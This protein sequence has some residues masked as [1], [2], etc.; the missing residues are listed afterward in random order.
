MTE[1]EHSS[2]CEDVD[3]LLGQA[4]DEYLQELAD[5]KQPAVEAYALNYPSI[6]NLIRRTLP[7]LEMINADAPAAPRI[8]E[9]D[10]SRSQ[11][12]GDFRLLRKLGSGGMGLVYEAEQ[13]SMGRRVAL[14][15]LPMAGTLQRKALERFRNEVRAAAMLDHPNIVSIYSVGEERGVHHFA[16]QLIR[17]QSLAEAIRELAR[18]DRVGSVTGTTMSKVLSTSGEHEQAVDLQGRKES[19]SNPL[20]GVCNRTETEVDV[21]ARVTTLSGSDTKAGYYR[22][23]AQLGVQAAEAL[24][25]AHV[26]GVFHRDIKPGNLMLDAN[27]NLFI[28][29]FGLARIEADVGITR[30][31]DLVGTLRYMSPEQAMAKRAI[32]DARSDI[33]SLGVTLYELVSLRPLFDSNDRQQLLQQITFE[34]PIKL[35]KLNRSIPAELETIIHKAIEKAP[36]DRYHSAAELAEDLLAFLEDRTIQAKPPSMTD[37]LTKWSRRHKPLVWTMALSTCAMVFTAMFALTASNLVIAQERRAAEQQATTANAVIAF[38]TDDLLG[39][40]NPLNEPNRD[41]RL[42]TVVDRAAARIDEK[43]ADQ[44][45]VAAAIRTTLGETYRAL[46]EFALAEEQLSA[47]LTTYTKLYGAE[48]PTTQGLRRKLALA[49]LDQGNDAEAEKLIRVVLDDRLK[50]FGDQHL[51]TAQSMSD[52]GEISL[53]CGLYSNAQR[54]FVHVVDLRLK[55]LGP[56]DPLTLDAQHRLAE[57]LDK[58]NKLQEAEKRFRHVLLH[59]EQILGPEHPGTLKTQHC[60][61]VLLVKQSKLD[62]A[63]TQFRRLLDSASSLLGDDHPFTLGCQANLASTL[64]RKGD[65]DE[66]R[67]LHTRAL[68]ES[69]RNLGTEHRLTLE[70]QMGLA[71]NYAA[72]HKHENA[73]EVYEGAYRILLDEFGET[74]PLTILAIEELSASYDA[75]GLHE[76]AGELR[77]NNNPPNNVNAQLALPLVS[78]RPLSF[79][80]RE[81][82][83]I[84]D[85]KARQEA[86]G[87]KQ[88]PN[89]LNG[90]EATI[91]NGTRVIQGRLGQALAFDGHDD[92]A[93]IPDLPEL[94]FTGSL[95]I[96]CCLKID[97]FPLPKDGHGVIVM[98]SDNRSGRDPYFLS[99]LP[100]GV[101]EFGVH[102]IE[103]GASIVAQVEQGKFLHVAATLDDATGFMRLYINGEQVAKRQ[104]TFR[105]FAKLLEF[106]EPGVGVGNHFSSKEMYN[107]P[108]HGIIEQLT[109]VDS[110]LTS[111]EIKKL[112]KKRLEP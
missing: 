18:C 106:R 37:K 31:G 73:V 57:A 99:T 2:P 72:Q 69:A 49:F 63:E 45:L 11:R 47:A 65:F 28:T 20:D 103:G 88:I 85:L 55:R 54:L 66:S 23:A 44:P 81:A 9:F 75:L 111:A 4:V 109:I 15:I 41:I 98:R 91:L 102:G 48:H 76:K 36:D 96:Q 105:P 101:I 108:F 24:Q 29:D 6:A 40:A 50:K 71:A 95:T 61:A 27:A 92:R 58:L 59:R 97:S 52:L 53:Y 68:E 70:T 60:L 56:E 25:H 19:D 89:V 62:D 112:A 22:S 51:D 42:R 82:L 39:A 100:S 104:T 107:F 80:A 38:I 110:A 33:Y 14:K 30:T 10:L 5:S 13:L 64:T 1:A 78:S 3:V 7:A 34:E 79:R 94:A 17:G 46:G 21:Q 93:N 16:M 67:E 87:A 35:R 26:Q 84:A 83:E 86:L 8:D 12:I 77:K 43:L 90:L 74:H 32:S